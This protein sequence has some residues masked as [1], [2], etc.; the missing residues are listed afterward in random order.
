MIAPTIERKSV[1]KKP[2]AKPPPGERPL[3]DQI[4]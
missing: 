4:L 3:R 2:S 1:K